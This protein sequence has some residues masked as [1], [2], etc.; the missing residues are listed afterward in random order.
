MQFWTVV[1][2]ESLDSEGVGEGGIELTCPLFPIHCCPES[3]EG[4]CAAA[5]WAREYEPMNEQPNTT[6]KAM[7]VLNGVVSAGRVRIS[8]PR[9]SQSYP[10]HLRSLK[11]GLVALHNRLLAGRTGHYRNSIPI[12]RGLGIRASESPGRMTSPG[13]DAKRC[14]AERR[15]AHNEAMTPRAGMALPAVRF[16]ARPRRERGEEHRG[17]GPQALAPGGHRVCA[18]LCRRGGK[19]RWDRTRGRVS[20]NRPGGVRCARNAT[21]D[22]TAD[23]RVTEIQFRFLPRPRH[24]S[25]AAHRSDN[26]G[27]KAEPEVPFH[28]RFL[29]CWPRR[30]ERAYMDIL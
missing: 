16:A 2:A 11:Q 6:T 14:G 20:S 12:W 22:A 18:R 13:A 15:R 5:Y 10:R 9:I 30:P 26:Q 19:S 24:P 8:R 3:Y 21:N 1:R 25:R 28:R 4:A 7:T 27:R 17:R 23:F 29:P